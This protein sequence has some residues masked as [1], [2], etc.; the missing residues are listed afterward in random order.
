MGSRFKVYVGACLEV[1]FVMQE[2]RRTVQGC[3]ACSYT[4]PG[5]FCPN[6]GDFLQKRTAVSTKLATLKLHS[7]PPEF[8]ELVWSPSE[9]PDAHV[10]WWL[11]N[12]GLGR[13]F[14]EGSADKGLYPVTPDQ[15]ARELA[16]FESRH[17]PLI[18][19]VERTHAITTRVLYGAVPYMD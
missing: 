12:R 6:C 4:G 18:D 13:S 19:Y 16:L 2:V 9:V 1:P 5:R 3:A 11:P 7:L 8:D 10:S 15:I 17:R 14:D